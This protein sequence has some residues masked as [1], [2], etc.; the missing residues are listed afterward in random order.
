MK[1]D[2]A[3][4]DRATLTQAAELLLKFPTQYYTCHCTG[5]AQYQF[6]KDLMGDQLQ[7]LAAGQTILVP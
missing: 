6:L 7:Y 1:L 4:E 2:P 3:T 5:L